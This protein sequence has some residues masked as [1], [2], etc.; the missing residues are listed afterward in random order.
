[1]EEFG[2]D[3][4]SIEDSGDQQWIF[5]DKPIKVET[6]FGMKECEKIF[7]NGKVPVIEIE[8]AD[9][10]T[11]TC[12]HNHRFLCEREGVEIWVRADELT[13]NDEIILG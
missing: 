7:Y 11:V 3:W 5:F 6:R 12:S 4:R 1:M 8:T 9:G 13:E 10:K 2:I